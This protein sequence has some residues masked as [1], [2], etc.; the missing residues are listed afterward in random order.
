MRSSTGFSLATGFLLVVAHVASG[1]PPASSR[2]EDALGVTNN[3]PLKEIA[4]G[5]FQLGK[6]RFDKKERIVSFPASINQTE[7][8]IEYLIVTSYGKTHESLLSTEAEPYHIQ[9]ALL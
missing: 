9:L 4:P 6:V 8:A 1:E 5:V 7:A 3:L 2:R